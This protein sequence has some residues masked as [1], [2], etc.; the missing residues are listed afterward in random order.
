VRQIRDAAK[1]EEY[2]KFIISIDDKLQDSVKTAFKALKKLSSKEK[3]GETS[4]IAAFKL[5]YSMTVLQVYS[6][7][8]DAV[9]MLDELEFCY[10]KFLGDKSSKQKD[11][12]DASDALVE[13]LLSFASKQ[14]QLFRRM[15]EQ[16]FGAFADQVTE[17][18][19]ESLI[20]VC[21]CDTLD[22]MFHSDCVLDLGS[23][24]ELGWP[25]RDVRPG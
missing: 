1:S 23:Q 22:C 6:G 25:A 14:S 13:I 20:S 17:N 12:S 7:D 19:L 10:T 16:V 11:T 5:L 8:A 24:G 18:G 21:T 4:S 3:K 2:G 9:S 15:S